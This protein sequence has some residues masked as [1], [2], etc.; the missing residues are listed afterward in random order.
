MYDN[1]PAGVDTKEVLK[2]LI[3]ISIPV[4]LGSLATQISGLIDVAMVQRQLHDGV[5]DNMS[6]FEAQYRHLFDEAGWQNII[7]HAVEADGKIVGYENQMHLFLYFHFFILP[8]LKYQSP[9]R[10]CVPV[11]RDRYSEDS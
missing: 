10:E 8:F 6:V 7:N 3:T 9:V 1:S 4:V 11:H 2:A 5:A